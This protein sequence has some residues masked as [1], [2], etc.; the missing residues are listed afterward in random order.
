M[1]CALQPWL[2]S[3]WGSLPAIVHTVAIRAGLVTTVVLTFGIALHWP[4]AWPLWR[5]LAG[6]ASALVFVYT[7][8]WCLA[9]LAA[10]GEPKLADLIYVGPGLGIAASGLA[11]TA[12]VAGGW[13]AATG[14]LMFG[15]LAL[16]LTVLVWS[17]LRGRVPVSAFAPS[18]PSAAGTGAMAVLS[19]AYGLAGFGYIV[20]ATFLPV[21]AR[22]SL[23]GSIW[24]NL[25]WPLFGLGVAV[26]GWE[27][28]WL[29]VVRH[30]GP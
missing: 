22:Q 10:L 23:P 6:I 14:W 27:S 30:G 17:G 2:W 18:Q 28:Y 24:L 5:F 3:R 25:F 1:A 9:C 7:L 15:V 8:G 26:N 20:T 16:V 11:A 21:I 12:I 29:R 13:S 19:I 4:A